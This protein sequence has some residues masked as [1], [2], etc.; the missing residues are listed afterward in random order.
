MHQRRSKLSGYWFGDNVR[1]PSR[2]E[3]QEARAHAQHELASHA[4][5]EH[6]ADGHQYDG[7]HEV[8]GDELRKH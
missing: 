1:R 8:T 6:A 5:E 7:R 4:G 2:E 3:L